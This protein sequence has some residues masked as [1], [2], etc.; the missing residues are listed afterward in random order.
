MRCGYIGTRLKGS[1]AS[2]IDQKHRNPNQIQWLFARALRRGS[3][4]RTGEIFF[5]FFTTHAKNVECFSRNQ[6]GIWGILKEQFLTLGR[7][8]DENCVLKIIHA[9]LKVAAIK[10][11]SI[12][13]FSFKED[14]K[15]SI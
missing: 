6:V 12:V 14:D 2:H 11:T 10:G 9:A 7:T 8:E 1:S 4:W 13:A 3:N 5:Q 15:I